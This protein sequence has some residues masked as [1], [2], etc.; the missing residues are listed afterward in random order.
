MEREN[1]IIQKLILEIQLIISER[2]LND[3]FKE[4]NRR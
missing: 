4:Y 3:E 2:K 1:Q